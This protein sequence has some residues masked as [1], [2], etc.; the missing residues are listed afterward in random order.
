[1]HYGILEDQI[2]WGEIMKKKKGFTL[3]EIIVAIALISMI[4]I[5]FLPAITFGFVRTIDTRKFTTESFNA[6]QDMENKLEE[7][8]KIELDDPNLDPDTVD[9]I[10]IFGVDVKG[11][12]VKQEIGPIDSNYGELVAFI[13]K[14]VVSYKVPVIVSP[15]VI[16]VRNN[17]T[18]ISPQPTEIDIL[19]NTKNLFVNEI[20]ISNETKSEFL[21][22]VYRWYYYD[23]YDNNSQPNSKDYQIIKEWNEARKILSYEDSED[24]GFIP[25]IKTDYNILKFNE[26]GLTTEELIE[27]FGGKYVRYSVTPFSLIGKIGKEE[28]SNQIYIKAP[29]L[30]VVNSAFL[31]DLSADLLTETSNRVLVTFDRPIKV[32]YF[33]IDKMN[34]NSNLGNITGAFRAF[35]DTKSL[36]VEFENQID[37]LMTYDNNLFLKGAVASEDYGNI[38][39]NN[40]VNGFTINKKFYHFSQDNN[41]TIG[42]STNNSRLMEV[43]NS[44][45]SN[46]AYIQIRDTSGTN[47]Q[48]WT[49]EPVQNSPYNTLLSNHQLNKALRENGATGNLLRDDKN[50]TNDNQLWIIEKSGSNFIIRPKNYMNNSIGTT[51]TSNDARVNL[52]SSGRLWTINPAPAP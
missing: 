29:E 1:M 38:Y 35:G 42:L 51:S 15:P 25:N 7:K 34:F 52:S 32:D 13:P 12:I 8:R 18:N 21:M 45:T 4:S 5:S 26:F 30:T 24:F 40:G 17:T 41:Y 23:N 49:I 20:D 36:V 48:I 2:R 22:N 16:K 28:F 33:N 6:Q 37:L 47:N 14:P 10:N 3:I 11:H 43:R 44:E 31:V 19:D 27:R 39:I 9:T 46:S 50:N